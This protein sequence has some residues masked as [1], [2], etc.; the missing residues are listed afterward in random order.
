MLTPA[1][2]EKEF[3]KQDVTL[4]GKLHR[5]VFDTAE[6]NKCSY[7]HDRSRMPCAHPGM[8]G[9]WQRKQQQ[10]PSSLTADAATSA[11][12]VYEESIT[13][14]TNDTLA[15]LSTTFNR[16]KKMASRCLE[17]RCGDIIQQ[18]EGFQKDTPSKMTEENKSQLKNL[19]TIR[20]RALVDL[21]KPLQRLRLNRHRMVRLEEDLLGYVF[22]LLPKEIQDIEAQAKL[23]GKAIPAGSQVAQVWRK[24]NDYV[25]RIVARMMQL[26][27]L[28]QQPLKDIIVVETEKGH[29]YTKRL[30]NLMIE[31]R[32]ELQSTKKS[33]D[34]IRG[35]AAQFEGIFTLPQKTSVSL[36]A[37]GP[38][39]LTEHKAALD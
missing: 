38:K 36:D 26:R 8:T 22:H 31:Q 37:S 4:I 11:R 32:Q 28:S 1:V 23:D 6:L 34:T 5:A 27:R 24:L 9:Y 35:V 13:P 12:K 19:K 7:D 29:G 2:E 15:N 18:I 14:S 21:L 20:K 17:E 33:M 3:E 10:C 16:L 39:M 25:Y 30:V